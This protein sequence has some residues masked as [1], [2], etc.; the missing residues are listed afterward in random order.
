[1][2]IDEL[3]AARRPGQGWTHIGGAVYEINGTRLHINGLAR[4]PSGQF[5]SAERW[6]A[7][8]EARKFIRMNGGNRKR[9]LMA[10]A[11]TLNEVDDDV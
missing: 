4:L 2:S 11:K 10:W 6:P 8:Q 1:M 7:Y 3:K 9:G 5:V